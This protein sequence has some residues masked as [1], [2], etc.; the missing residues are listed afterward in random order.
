MLLNHVF[1]SVSKL[2]MNTYTWNF[3]IILQLTTLQV[4]SS[5]E[6]KRNGCF[7]THTQWDTPPNTHRVYTSLSVFV[8][9]P[10]HSSLVSEHWKKN[11]KK[12]R[13]RKGPPISSQRPIPEQIN[14]VTSWEK[15][16]KSKFLPFNL[17]WANPLEINL[18]SSEKNKTH[19]SETTKY[20]TL[21]TKCTH[22]HTHAHTHARTHT[23]THTHIHTCAHAHTHCD[24][25]TDTHT[26]TRKITKDTLALA[27][28]RQGFRAPSAGFLVWR[29]ALIFLTG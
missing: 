5:F 14:H 15:P 13:R 26:R 1:L 25:H 19:T 6:R 4:N 17:L 2:W 20:T 12:T 21:T 10:P 23:R 22:T 9:S 24:T 28:Q 29:A 7:H 8:T 3:F 16:H 11:K 27:D 18:N